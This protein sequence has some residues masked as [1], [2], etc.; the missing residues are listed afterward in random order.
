MFG[1]GL[2]SANL[3]VLLCAPCVSAS[4]F[5][6]LYQIEYANHVM[7]MIVI[8][9][10]F[11]KRFSYDPYCVCAPHLVPYICACVCVCVC[12][13][14]ALLLNNPACHLHLPDHRKGSRALVLPSSTQAQEK[15]LNVPQGKRPWAGPAVRRSPCLT[16]HL[17]L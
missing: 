10:C 1:C 16:T 13:L 2:N 11:D 9:F 3:P 14:P 15:S 7:P 5:H 17:G 8:V 6:R 12:A 4:P